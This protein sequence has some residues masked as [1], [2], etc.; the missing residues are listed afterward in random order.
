MKRKPRVKYTEEDILCAIAD[1]KNGHCSY[2]AAAEKYKI[3]ISTLCDKIKLRVS[4]TAKQGID[5]I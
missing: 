2:R 5:Y 4:L 3:P 1:V